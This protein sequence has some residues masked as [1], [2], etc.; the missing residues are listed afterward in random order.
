MSR[1]VYETDEDRQREREIAA[2]VAKAWSGEMVKLTRM[3]PIDYI[4]VHKGICTAWVEIK[5]RTTVKNNYPTYYIDIDKIMFGR[6]MS[7]ETGLP[8]LVVVAWADQT[9]FLEITKNYPIRFAGRVDRDDWH[10]KCPVYEIPINEFQGL[11]ND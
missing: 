8:F 3:Y 7:K 5:S 2:K 6:Q 11:E 1:P 4:F 9:C 10:D